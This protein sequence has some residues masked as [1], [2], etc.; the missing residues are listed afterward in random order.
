ML[1]C[2]KRP[3]IADLKQNKAR[4]MT[5]YKK[6]LLLKNRWRMWAVRNA[7]DELLEVTDIRHRLSAKYKL[8]KD[9]KSNDK[10]SSEIEQIE[11]VFTD[12]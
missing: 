9:I 3:C 12:V 6:I 2:L 11:I 1:E 7:Y 4:S 8:E 5:V 10:L